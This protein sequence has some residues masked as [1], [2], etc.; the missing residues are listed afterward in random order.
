MSFAR[1]LERAARKSG[2]ALSEP[3]LEACVRH[4]E[5]LRSW[6]ATHNLT[7]LVEHEDAARLHYL[8]CLAPL[9]GRGAPASYIDVGSGA[10]FPGLMAALAWPEARGVLVEPSRKRGSFLQLA[11]A[12]MGCRPG[13]VVVE[14]STGSGAEAALVLSR[15]TFSGARR[16][17]LAPYVAAGGE[18]W[19]W[20]H[21]KN[22]AT[23]QQTVAT[24]G[25]RAVTPLRYRVSGVEERCVLRA[26]SVGEG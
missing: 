17:E 7:R 20:G 10:G 12:A 5:L 19:V 26:R 9:L 3:V 4:F 6:N 8:D 24:W 18:L 16:A 23:W 22:D 13:A 1:V 15:A 21:E 11:A 2:V 14:A 25:M